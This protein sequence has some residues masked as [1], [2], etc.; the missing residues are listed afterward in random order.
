MSSLSAYLLTGHSLGES[1]SVTIYELARLLLKAPEMLRRNRKAKTSVIIEP[2]CGLLIAPES[3]LVYISLTPCI[4]LGNL[5]G[6]E[7]G[8]VLDFANVLHF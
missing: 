1:N 4:E 2:P 5:I 3:A 7:L 8:S 6:I